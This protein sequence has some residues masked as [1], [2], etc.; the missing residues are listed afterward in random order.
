MKLAYKGFVLLAIAVA[1]GAGSVASTVLGAEVSGQQSGR[2]TLA[3]SP[4]IVTGNIIVPAG[5]MLTIDPG[6]IVKFAGY[7]GLRVE[8]T[9]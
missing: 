5:M 1:F 6:V 4:Y 7:Y 3:G 9:L 8:G 2:W